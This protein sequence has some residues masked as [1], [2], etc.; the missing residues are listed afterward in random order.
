MYVLA[1]SVYCAY[2]VTLASTVID[3]LP[4]S[5]SIL[6]AMSEAERMVQTGIKPDMIFGTGDTSEQI[7]EILKEKMRDPIELKKKFWDLF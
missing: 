4:E 7:L 5:D 1:I 6:R 3:C 2:K